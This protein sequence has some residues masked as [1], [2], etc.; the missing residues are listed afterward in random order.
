MKLVTYT[1]IEFPLISKAFNEPLDSK[2]R[3]GN[4]LTNF[5]KGFYYMELS[6]SKITTWA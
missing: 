5:F 6:D 3:M 2:K 4:F 1:I